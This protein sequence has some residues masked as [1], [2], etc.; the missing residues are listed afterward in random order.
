MQKQAKR[1]CFFCVP[2]RN[3]PPPCPRS[4]LVR[5]D[6]SRTACIDSVPSRFDLYKPLNSNGRMTSYAEVISGNPTQDCFRLAENPLRTL[7][8][9]SHNHVLESCRQ[10]RSWPAPNTSAFGRSRPAA[11]ASREVV[12]RWLLY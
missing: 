2:R 12:E 1:R 6:G 3:R 4:L 8:F 11:D 10:S 5:T 7:S 9:T